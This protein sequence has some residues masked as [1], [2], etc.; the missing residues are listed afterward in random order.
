MVR[1]LCIFN[2]IENSVLL[3]PCFGSFS[4]NQTV[5]DFH[6]L[7]TMEDILDDISAK[8]SQVYWLSIPGLITLAILL[9]ETFLTKL[10]S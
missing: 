10:K 3:H 6:I 5:A 9:P 1:V 7:Q 2:R 8:I 4:R